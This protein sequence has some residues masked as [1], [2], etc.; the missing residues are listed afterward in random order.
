MPD[1]DPCTAP[2]SRRVAVAA[3]L[4]VTD[5]TVP[6]ARAGTVRT[7][8]AW[9]VA[10][11]AVEV[12]ELVVSELVS[13]A[14]KAAG[15]HDQVAIRL[16][17]DLDHVL[18]E[19]WNPGTSLPQRRQPGADDEGGRGLVLVE[20]LTETWGS[21]HATSGGTV[22]YARIAGGIGAVSPSPDDC[23]LATRVPVIRPAPLVPV[24]FRTDLETLRRVADR[25]R[26]L[27][28]W[29]DDPALD[30]STPLSTAAP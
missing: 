4:P 27:D 12:A 11:S 20:A 24:M 28:S 26:A 16:T 9:S 6:S 14:I 18:V 1:S 23:P 29:H 22:V 7:L 30:T 3:C 13:N 2:V 5:A 15:W 17:A 8:T 21:Y 10:R 19:V 25:L